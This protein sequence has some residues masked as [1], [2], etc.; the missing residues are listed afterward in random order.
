MRTI[1]INSVCLSIPIYVDVERSLRSFA[2]GTVVVIE[3]GEDPV[4]KILEA[5]FP[6]WQIEM[7]DVGTNID[8]DT[9][10]LMVDH[11]TDDGFR[12]RPPPVPQEANILIMT[13][14]I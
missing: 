14:I 7:I 2:R 12:F 11:P 9:F 6:G 13:Q 4:R 10:T 5:I 3:Q 1:R 8:L